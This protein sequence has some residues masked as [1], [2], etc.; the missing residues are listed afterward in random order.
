MGHETP[1]NIPTTGASAPTGYPDVEERQ[2]FVGSGSLG[3]CIQEFCFPL[4]REVQEKWLEG[5][6]PKGNSWT[7]SPAISIPEKESGKITSQRL[8]GLWIFNGPM[9][10]GTHRSPHQTALPHFLSPQSCLALAG[11]HGLELSETGTARSPEKRE[12][13]RA[14]ETVCVAPYKKTPKSSKPTWFLS[15]RVASC[16]SLTLNAH[17]RPE[18]ALL[19]FTISTN[20]TVSPPLTLWWSPLK[21]NGWRF[22][23]VSVPETLKAGTFNC[24]SNIF[25]D[26]CEVTSSFCGTGAPFTDTVRF[27]SSL[28]N[29]G[30]FI[31]NS[32]QLMPQNSIPQSMCGIK[33]TPL[34]PITHPEICLDSKANLTFPFGESSPLRNFSGLVYMP[35]TCRGRDSQ[36]FLYLCE[37]Q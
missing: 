36:S 7:T 10:F 5:T 29:I 28:Q 27:N 25:S 2:T 20:K 30:E 3:R 32:F 19:S 14:L 26:T 8:S 23:C 18:D 4:V 33:P 24:S 37:T 17:G 21:E 16:S 1:R 13:N 15:T 9:D 11:S 35:P 31:L 12:G 34:C 22:I 6:S